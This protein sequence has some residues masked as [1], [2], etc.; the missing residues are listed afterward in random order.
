MNNKNF[1][2]KI[3]KINKTYHLSLNMQKKQKKC[4]AY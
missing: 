4:Y 3:E 1:L 2:Q